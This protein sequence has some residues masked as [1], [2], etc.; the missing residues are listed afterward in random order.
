MKKKIIPMKLLP[1]LFNKKKYFNH[2]AKVFLNSNSQIIIQLYLDFYNKNK[3][4][5][6]TYYKYIKIKEYL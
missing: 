4:T 6:Y 5:Y 1:M 2:L 3:T